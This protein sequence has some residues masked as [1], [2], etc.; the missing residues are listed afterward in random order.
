MWH[1][2]DRGGGNK[3]EPPATNGRSDVVTQQQPRDRFKCVKR[4]VTATKLTKLGYLDK[5]P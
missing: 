3:A 2:G 1:D 5:K 4:W